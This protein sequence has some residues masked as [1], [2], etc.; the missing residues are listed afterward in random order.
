MRRPKGDGIALRAEILV[1]SFA[2]P[3]GACHRAW[4]KPSKAR[5]WDERGGGGD[6]RKAGV[7][8]DLAVA[9]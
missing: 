4:G 1:R 5:P 8:G 3:V 9:R 6:P 7:S 2:G